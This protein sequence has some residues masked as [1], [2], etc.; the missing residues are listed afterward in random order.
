M[1]LLLKTYS[2]ED[3]AKMAQGLLKSNNIDSVLSPGG[4]N[5]AATMSVI[6]G[7]D[8]MCQLFIRD[9][10]LEKAKEVLEIED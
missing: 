9:T 8:S 5:G 6:T 7:L 10:D 2:S 3:N 4:G 1:K